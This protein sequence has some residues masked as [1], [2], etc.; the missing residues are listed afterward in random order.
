MDHR[1]RD[2]NPTLRKMKSFNQDLTLHDGDNA[3]TNPDELETPITRNEEEIVV[4]KKKIFAGVM[5]VI[6]I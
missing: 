6:G 5:L 1:V 4:N 3:E 2:Q